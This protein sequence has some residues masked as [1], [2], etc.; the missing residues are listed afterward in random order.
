MGVYRS[1]SAEL[2]E[3]LSEGVERGDAQAI[4]QAAHALKSSSLNVG[5]QLLGSLCRQLEA[6]G[7]SGEVD[8]AKNLFARIAAERERAL[9]ALDA[10]AAR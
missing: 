10:E 7:A 5:A 2:L 6:L 1:S 9:E 8:G 3:S 4:R